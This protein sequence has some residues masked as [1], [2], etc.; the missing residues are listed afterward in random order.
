MN[1]PRHLG[2]SFSSI[3]AAVEEQLERALSYGC[4]LAEIVG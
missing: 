4:E 2:K 3:E 1:K